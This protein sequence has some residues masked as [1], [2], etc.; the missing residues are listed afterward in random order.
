[1]DELGNHV[2]G[3]T[4]EATPTGV[5]STSSELRKRRSTRIV[6]AVPLQ[7]TGVDALGRPFVERTSS[8][9]L[10]CH[11]CRYQS[12][13]Y[14]LKNMWVRLEIPHPEENHEPRMVRGRVAWIQ[15]PRT[16]RQLFQVALE[17]EVP[18]NVWGIGFPPEDWFNFSEHDK[19]HLAAGE[20]AFGSVPGSTPWHERS[21]DSTLERG[22][23]VPHDITPIETPGFA[24][25]TEIHVSLNEAGE[26]SAPATASSMASTPPDKIRVFP[27]PN[28]ATDA[29]L[30]LARQLTR[31]LADARQQI[32]T[33]AREAAAQAVSAERLTS[34]E[35]WQK[36]LVG[37]QEELAKELA[38]A[39]ARIQEESAAN[40]P[41][42]EASSAA[43]R[44]EVFRGIAPQ[45]EE[46]VREV[47]ATV[48]E[49][50][51]GQ[52]DQRSR[53]AHDHVERLRAACQ[54]AE[55]AGGRLRET[56]DRTAAQIGARAEDAQRAL[57]D[58]CRLSEEQLSAQRDAL[59]TELTAA[60]SCW[61][62]FLSGELE[63]AQ[64]RW[65]IAVDNALLDVQDRASHTVQ[66]RGE[67]LLA[68]LQ[69]QTAR[70]SNGLR[71]T[72]NSFAAQS[73]QHVAALRDSLDS[74]AR[75]VE[76]LLGQAG[77]A[78]E[79]VAGFSARLD[80]VQQEALERFQGQVDDVLSLHRNE[81]H[82]RSDA[83]FGE[84]SG[85]IR[86]A[87]DDSS[88]EAAAT[89]SEQIDAMI[90]PQIA[91]SDEAMQRL[92]GGRSLLDA[93][94]SL[95]QDRVREATNAAF[96]DALEGFRTELAGAEKSLQA[97]A[98]TMTTK[99]I[100]E[101]EGRLEGLKQQTAED[102]AKS[103]EWYEKR[104][105]TQI[106]VVS[107][108][109]SEQ[110]AAHLRDKAEDIS[111]EF[112]SE[113]DQSSKNFVSYAQGQMAEV[114]SDA[115]ERARALFSEA[116]E[117]TSAAFVDE[118]Q[119]HA[120]QDLEGFTSELQDSTAQARNQVESA[121][122][123]LKHRLTTEQEDFLRRFHTAMH[124]AVDQGV[125]SAHE[126]VHAGFEPLLAAWNTAKHAHQAEMQAV[127]SQISEQAADQYRDRLENV[128]NQWM[129]AT[130]SSLD[131]QS[132]D[133]VAR[134]ASVA[135]ETL[136]E[137]CSQVFA[138]IGEA[139]RERLQQ[140]ASTLTGPGAKT[141]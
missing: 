82:R 117:T 53:E 91:K 18:G 67:Q 118:I 32:Q 54:Q 103:A 75:R 80:T 35:H 112:A 109:V 4:T 124:G 43:L 13:H 24:P 120:R 51:A 17:L 25:E 39:I 102:L 130:V 2:A 93:A 12:K 7:V 40:P 126:K 122:A 94:M 69:E 3:E 38:T 77:E 121:H 14:V 88:R 129:L 27:S 9:I 33:A 36:R 125:A 68:K 64:T 115:F 8:L 57:Q 34:E 85:R 79:R 22:H 30:Q 1:M 84:I 6:Q 97:A 55:E 81:L 127:S 99:T 63:A 138:D 65:Q 11:G 83:L 10:N 50:R 89:F 141:S 61:Q 92:A 105:Q 76:G 101:V 52:L 114:V 49:Q 78:S 66:E 90:Q 23:E 62:A 135:D 95:Q 96:A 104:A 70:L 46:L 110:T 137:T 47:S 108:K 28:S 48:Q 60:Q 123:E 106:Q 139:L 86:A 119:R 71:E 111:N 116:A 72:A 44:D 134:I 58:A 31:L 19:G 41:T 133:A 20:S 5:T 131:H 128:S 56:A 73:E 42:A 29:S 113:L 15:R 107:E 45:V 74:Q 37:A 98:D 87:F 59:N 132:R 16:V 26:P 136:R 140:I 100:T 21:A